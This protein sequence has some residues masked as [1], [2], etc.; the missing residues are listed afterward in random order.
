MYVDI[1]TVRK[2][3]KHCLLLGRKWLTSHDQFLG[4]KAELVGLFY[5]LLMTSRLKEEN[6]L[7]NFCI[8][9]H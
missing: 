6:K 1:R 8:H 2:Q 4:K 9:R 5:G 3:K 7:T